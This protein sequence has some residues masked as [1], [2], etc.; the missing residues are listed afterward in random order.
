MIAAF[1]KTFNH[2]AVVT[3]NTDIRWRTAHSCINKMYICTAIF[4]I[5]FRKC[6]RRNFNIAIGVW[7]SKR[8]FRDGTTDISQCHIFTISCFCNHIFQACIISCGKKA[9]CFDRTT[10]LICHLKFCI[11]NFFSFYD[12][13]IN[14][15]ICC[16]IR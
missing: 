7:R 6:F 4:S 2:V 1:R 12:Y 9:V 5:F 10:N 14:E 11:F 15:E 16:R 8:S 13:I 3:D